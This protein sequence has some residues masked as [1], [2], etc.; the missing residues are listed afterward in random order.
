MGNVRERTRQTFWMGEVAV[1]QERLSVLAPPHPALRNRMESVKGRSAKSPQDECPHLRQRYSERH[2]WARG[3]FWA[4]VGAV[5]VTTVRAY[6]ESQKWGGGTEGF[7]IIA[8]SPPR[9]GSQAALAAATT[10]RR[11]DI[12]A[13]SIGE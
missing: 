11:K 8:P 9:A 6:I 13:A 1:D 4:T 5:K 3:A 10:F 2:L 7:R 12:S